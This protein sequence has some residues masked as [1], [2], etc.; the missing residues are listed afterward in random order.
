MGRPVAHKIRLRIVGAESNVRPIN[1][2]LPEG[3]SRGDGVRR[4]HSLVNT[5]VRRT[6]DDSVHTRI[7]VPRPEDDHDVHCDQPQPQGGQCR[8]GRELSLI[9]I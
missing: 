2:P 5:R 1:V 6:P 4:I 7:G 9:H 8:P 3:L